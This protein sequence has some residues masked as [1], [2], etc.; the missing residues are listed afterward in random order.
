MNE[1]S[2]QVSESHINLFHLEI[3][4]HEEYY[5]ATALQL[6]KAKQ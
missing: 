6:V 2:P 4:S 1:A 5:K 3:I